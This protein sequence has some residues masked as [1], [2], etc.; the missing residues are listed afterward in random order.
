M[1][2][3]E[4]ATLLVLD[5]LG[6]EPAQDWAREPIQGLV[7]ARYMSGRITITTT[8]LTHVQLIDRYGTAL[9]RRLY[10]GRSDG[11]QGSVIEATRRAA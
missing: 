7:D 4:M 6:Q 2:K 10:E 9:V 5:D 1:A 3:L 11:A 8:E